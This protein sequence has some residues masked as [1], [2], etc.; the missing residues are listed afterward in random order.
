MKE[1]NQN[2]RCEVCVKR[3]TVTDTPVRVFTDYKR[4]QQIYI[5][6]KDLEEFKQQYPKAT[7]EFVRF[8]LG[9][10]HEG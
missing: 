9:I 2:K 3:G 1:K 7:P 10:K 5:C 4:K 8:C 6:E